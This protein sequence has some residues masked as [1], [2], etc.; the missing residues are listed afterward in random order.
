VQW[1]LSFPERVLTPRLTTEV[2]ERAVLQHRGLIL[3]RED[4][5]D[6]Q[7]GGICGELTVQRPPREVAWGVHSFF[8]I[9]RPLCRNLRRVESPFVLK[10]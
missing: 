3:R 2:P 8:G 5:S 7:A 4:R 6:T 10:V 1:A 9:T